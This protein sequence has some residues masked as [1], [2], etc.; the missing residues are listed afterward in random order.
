MPRQGR[1]CVHELSLTARDHGQH[2]QAVDFRQLQIEQGDGRVAFGAIGELT[3]A[4]QVVER[5][6]AVAHDHDFIGELAA[7]QGHQGQLEVVRVILD[8][9]DGF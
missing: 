4:Q 1:R 2:F 5:F 6:G 3:A 9:Q 7:G 8:Q